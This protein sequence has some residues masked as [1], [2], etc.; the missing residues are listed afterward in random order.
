MFITY[1]NLGIK[2]TDSRR[3][4]SL[5][6]VT[7]DRNLIQGFYLVADQYNCS[8]FNKERLS[9]SN[10][11]WDVDIVISLTQSLVIIQFTVV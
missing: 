8:K 1:I 9:T 10:F 2:W 7:F 4:E 6:A 11:K 3:M 5:A